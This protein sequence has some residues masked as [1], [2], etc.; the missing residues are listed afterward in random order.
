MLWKIQARKCLK[1]EINICLNST[2]LYIKRLKEKCLK[3]IQVHMLFNSIQRLCLDYA[4][5]HSCYLLVLHYY[6]EYFKEFDERKLEMFILLH[7]RKVIVIVIV[8]SFT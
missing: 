2:S 6:F 7:G 1:Q 8:I 3:P 5:C 4:S